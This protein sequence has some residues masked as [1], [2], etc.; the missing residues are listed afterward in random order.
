[1]PK[2]SD[3][4]RTLRYTIIALYTQLVLGLVYFLM[5]YDAT[6]AAIPARNPEFTEDQVRQIS[7]S[8]ILVQCLN[9]LI[10][11]V[12][13]Y[14]LLLRKNWAR[15]VYLILTIAGL[16]F[17]VP[18]FP[19]WLENPMAGITHLVTISISIYA[20]YVLFFASTK[21]YFQKQGL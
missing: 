16:P 3:V 18:A 8:M 13:F 11:A 4:P 6:V 19:R 17:L 1:M 20:I 2:F 7:R 14:F 10:Y 15:I 5:T 9:T 12:L 21:T